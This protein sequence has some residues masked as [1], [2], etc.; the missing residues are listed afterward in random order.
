MPSMTAAAAPHSSAP[1]AMH[2]PCLP[3]MLL[4]EDPIFDGPHPV[5]ETTCLAAPPDLLSALPIWT[6]HDA[7]FDLF[8]S[9]V[10]HMPLRK[11]QV[12]RE[13][14]ELSVW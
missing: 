12:H 4:R 7:R 6:R 13:G 11:A 10:P 8:K 14:I 9:R 2:E 5:V 3:A 1:G